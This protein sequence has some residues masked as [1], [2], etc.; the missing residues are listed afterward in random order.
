[1]VETPY[2]P[3]LPLLAPR[4][5]YFAGDDQLR[6]TVNNSL[7]G[8]TVRIVGR[9]LTV[10]GKV[11]PF[12]DRVVPASDRTASTRTFQLGCG[13]LLEAHAIVSAGAPVSGQTFATFSIVRGQTGAFDDLATLAA[14]YITAQQ[15][16]AFPFTGV[17]SSLD[18]DGALRII[19]GATPG[20]GAELSETVPTGARWELISL[21]FQLVT[22][23]APGNRNPDLIFDDGTNGYFLIES[24]SNFAASGTFQFCYAQGFGGQAQGAVNRIPLPLPV[25]GRLG[26]GHRIR[27]STIGILA[28]D[29]YSI[30]FYEVR[31][32]IEGA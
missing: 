16:C 31:E 11:V 32:W 9:F 7:A 27:T 24:G 2:T 3:D 20:A 4:G 13:W 17:K 15:R 1:M 26:A 22:S 30:L 23:A 6:C 12:A 8:V 25:N 5:V 29:Q 21:R 14:C 18:G 28:G 10:E 19:T